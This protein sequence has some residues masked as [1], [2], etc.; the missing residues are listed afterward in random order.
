MSNMPDTLEIAL[1]PDPILI[2]MIEDGKS[3]EE[4]IADLR[5]KYADELIK[6]NNRKDHTPDSFAQ[7]VDENKALPTDIEKA[8][9]DFEELIRNKLESIRSS[10]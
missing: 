5:T 6:H 9:G 8:V 3:D 1:N 2:E 4:I 10:N 7:K